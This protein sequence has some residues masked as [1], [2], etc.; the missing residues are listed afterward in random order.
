MDWDE[1]RFFHTV[2]LTGSL[3]EAARRLKVSQPTV[4]RRIK[5]LEDRLE[6]RLFDRLPVGFVL[7]D[8]G[9]AIF[10]KAEEMA[11]TA[12]SISDRV[13]GVNHRAEGRVSLTTSEC[14]G[15]VW[16]TPNLMKLSTIHPAL[17]VE[18]ALSNE[19]LDIGR[20]EADLA[21]RLGSPDDDNLVGRQ[22]ATAAFHLWASRDY[23]QTFGV[24]RT[25]DELSRHRI[26]ESGGRIR[27]VPQARFLREV[28]RG[29]EVAGTFDCISAQLA[30]ARAGLGLASL[31]AYQTASIDDLCCV[32][33]GSF[34]VSVPVWLLT[35]NDLRGSTRVNALKS[36]LSKAVLDA[37]ASWQKVPALR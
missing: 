16:L 6:A 10:E 15:A 8:A 20:G 3:S 2:A 26:I 30:A 29:A 37:R 14:L 1:I 7:N 11:A 22:I 24:P 4:G 17:T 27:D 31:P 25:L 28:A 21:L 19:K 18:L 34:Y 23:L 33:P 12:R 13:S 9:Q 32:L 36:F 5:M 35:R